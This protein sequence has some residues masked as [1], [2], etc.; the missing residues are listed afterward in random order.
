MSAD[1]YPSRYKDVRALTLESDTLKVQFLPGM[2][3]KMA[4]LLYKPLDFEL[5]VQ[6]PGKRYR[7]QPFDGVYVNG[8]CS[9]FDDMFPTIDACAYER[10]PWKG[11]P[12]ADHGEV[13]SLP[14]TETHAEDRIHFSV[15]GIRFPYR[16]EKWACIEPTG[17]LRLD[18]CLTNPTPFEMDFLWAAHMMINLSEGCLLTLPAGV[19]KIVNRL[20]F[21]GNLGGFGDEFDWP[22]AALKEDMQ[23]DLRIMRPRT[24]KDADKYFVKGKMPEGWC[25]VDYPQESISLK[26]SFPVDSV[27]YLG[28]LT[29]EMGFDNLYNIFIEPCTGSFDRIDIARL[30][31]ENSVIPP[32]SSLRWSLTVA[33]LPFQA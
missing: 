29:N 26:I 21:N 15:S 14:W 16:L 9:G 18:Y 30:R 33:V 6:R 1:L 2:G 11:I 13:W 25:K 23:R 10:A 19:N 27:P 31:G 22:I 7:R 28:I 8:E 32:D 24:T 4:S 3:A 17:S 5:L 12:L 20:S